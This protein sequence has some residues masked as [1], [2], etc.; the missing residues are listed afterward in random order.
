MWVDFGR[1]QV[2]CRGARA[3]LIGDVQELRSTAGRVLIACA[4]LQYPLELV[5]P[6]MSQFIAILKTSPNWRTRLDVLLPLQS[7]SK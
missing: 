2:G 7:R 1:D 6:L 5:K 4:C 3:D